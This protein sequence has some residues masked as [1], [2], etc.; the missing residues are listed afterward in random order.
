MRSLSATNKCWCLKKSLQRLHL[1][2]QWNKFVGWITY[3]FHKV[4]QP[5]KKQHILHCY[6]DLDLW[7][8]NFSKKIHI[9]VKI[10]KS[11]GAAVLALIQFPEKPPQ[12]LLGRWNW[13]KT[14]GEKKTLV[15]DCYMP[16]CDVVSNHL[17]C[18][19]SKPPPHQFSPKKSPSSTWYH[20]LKKTQSPTL[21]H[22]SPLLVFSPQML[23][24]FILNSFT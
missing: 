15:K 8:Y 18:G 23:F 22:R 10:E 20:L 24:L 4:T 21:S 5:P 9:F 19:T 1:W 17:W 11:T 12:F 3:H 14:G 6:F 16:L 2:N 7:N 13:R